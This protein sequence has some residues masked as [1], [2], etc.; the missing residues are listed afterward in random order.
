MEYIDVYSRDGVLIRG[1]VPKHAPKVPGDY[2]RHVL[3]I[4]KTEDSPAPGKGEGMYVVQQRSLRARHYAGKW[5]MTGGG[6][7]SGESPEEAALRELEEELCLTLPREALKP[8]F[9][10]TLD[11]GDGTGLL[12][13][14]FMCRVP[15]PE[16]GFRFDRA[17]VNDVKIMPFREFLE[18]VRDHNDEA[19]CRGLEEIEEVL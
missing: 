19:F 10:Y 1:P 8:G 17:E 16:G 11:R 15:V 13:T 6:V 7:R 4:L 18:H 3:I 5:D 14:V 12:L 9:A 2:A